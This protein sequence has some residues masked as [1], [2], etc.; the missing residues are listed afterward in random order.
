VVFASYEIGSAQN[1]DLSVV[2][3]QVMVN[4]EELIGIT[5]KFG[6]MLHHPPLL[7]SL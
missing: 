2:C 3:N 7:L 6:Y 5:K 1:I 4:S